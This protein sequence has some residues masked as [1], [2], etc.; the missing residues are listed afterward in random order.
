MSQQS[1]RGRFLM[2]LSYSRKKK[3]RTQE[4][5]KWRKWRE[6]KERDEDERWHL[7]IETWEGLGE[8]MMTEFK[9]SKVHL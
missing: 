4:I 2:L 5:I 3:N 6:E 8:T 1:E 7:E 9:G